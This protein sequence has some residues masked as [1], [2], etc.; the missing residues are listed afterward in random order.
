MID[1]PAGTNIPA[2][3]MPDDIAF[4]GDRLSDVAHW[5]KLLYDAMR[6]W[7][8]PNSVMVSVNPGVV[9]RTSVRMRA[10]ALIFSGGTANDDIGIKSNSSSSAA[11]F[12]FLVPAS[13]G[14]ITIP[15]GFTMEPG[16]DYSV[17][18]LTTPANTNYRATIL[19]YVEME[20]EAR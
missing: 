6:G 4:L 12:D 10:Y 15:V 13:P 8:N 14:V 2:P 18:D 3:G 19:A 7:L 20:H 17:V 16:Q 5:T 1:Y 11:F 9:S